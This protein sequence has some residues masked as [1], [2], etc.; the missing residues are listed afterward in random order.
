MKN[1]ES[2]GKYLEHTL[3][4]AETTAEDI[5]RICNEAKENGFAA[6]VVRGCF[7]KL[8]KGCLEGSGVK[9]CSAVGATTGMNLTSVKVYEAR[10]LVKAGADELD[11]YINMGF[12]KSEMWDEVYEDLKRVIDAVRE[13]KQHIPVKVIVENGILYESDK[14]RVYV[15]AEKAG[16]DYIKTGTGFVPGVATVADVRLIRE[17]VPGLKIKAASHVYDYRKAKE[18]IEAGADRIGTGSAMKI[19]AQEKKCEG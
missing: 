9:V 12:I 13:F 10:E 17:T 15:L 2:I 5:K 7:V 19:I 4:A 1:N 3:L 18:L 6:V 14:K 8:A 16:A 11:L